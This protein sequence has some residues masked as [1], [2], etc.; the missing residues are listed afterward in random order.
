MITWPEFETWNLPF[1]YRI[2][3]TF[4]RYRG[5]KEHLLL[6]PKHASTMQPPD[7]LGSPQ[8]TRTDGDQSTRQPSGPIATARQCSSAGRPRNVNAEASTHPRRLTPAG[9]H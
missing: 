3:A 4:I 9:N 5:K 1:E 6:P 8:Q 7:I 2:E